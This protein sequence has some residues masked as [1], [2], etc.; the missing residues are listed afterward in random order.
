MRESLVFQLFIFCFLSLVAFLFFCLSFSLLCLLTR[1]FATCCDGTSFTGFMTGWVRG[2]SGRGNARMG[3][4]FTRTLVFSTC[5][6]ILHICTL[7][8][9]YT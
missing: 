1:C 6:R 3:T 9:R 7:S 5:R 8:R 2:H 4:G